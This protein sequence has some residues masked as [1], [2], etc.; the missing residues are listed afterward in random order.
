MVHSRLT[1]VLHNI[2]SDVL[3]RLSDVGLQ[4]DC[5]DYLLFHERLRH[6]IVT[7][8]CA[9]WTVANAVDV[10]SFPGSAQLSVTCSMVVFC[11]LTR[12]AWETVCGL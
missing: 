11:T 1:S 4:V 12:R 3:Y 9:L 2:H 6:E 8:S 5:R 7:S 10:A